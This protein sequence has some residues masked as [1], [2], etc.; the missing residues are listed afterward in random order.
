MKVTQSPRSFG[1]LWLWK[2]K[3]DFQ[4]CVFLYSDIIE[5]S[6]QVG[7]LLKAVGS[8]YAYSKVATRSSMHFY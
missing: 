3:A 4:Q 1:Q 5:T 6:S 7:L 8:F 2:L